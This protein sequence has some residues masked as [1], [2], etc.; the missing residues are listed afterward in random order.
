MRQLYLTNN[1]CYKRNTA[2]ADSRYIRF[3]ERGPQG[4]MMHSTGAD[5][6]NLRRYVGPDDGNLGVNIYGNHWNNPG[7]DVC[8][9]AFI[10]ETKDGSVECYQNL[11]WNYRGW[12]SGAEAN[13]THI[14]IEIC[15][16][17]LKSAA[18]FRATRDM[19]LDVVSELCMEFGFDPLTNGILI[20]HSEGAAM[21]IASNHGDVTHWWSRFGYS[22][23]HF[24][25]DV[26][27]RM[28]EKE[29][30]M[31]KEIEDFIRKEIKTAVGNIKIPMP[32]VDAAAAN[33]AQNAVNGALSIWGTQDKH[34]RWA[35]DAIQWAKDNKLVN[36]HEAGNFGWEKP[37]TR[38][39]LIT[40]LHRF[41][42]MLEQRQKA[43]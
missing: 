6:P 15:E 43:Q 13:D 7:L 20:D 41:S 28:K 31:K 16:D 9:H 33:A 27:R 5:N 40:I 30:A 12:H 22:M 42:L 37:I 2:K 17:D 21:G 25:R 32:N 14:S 35:D 18:Y 29:N 24:R 26:A 8:V 38:E 3:Q 11:P 10:G 4:I 39:E 34:S 1:D 19:A 23:N 36:G